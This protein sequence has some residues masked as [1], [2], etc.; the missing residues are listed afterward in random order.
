MPPLHRLPRH[1]LRRSSIL[2]KPFLED[3]GIEYHAPTFMGVRRGGLFHPIAPP[4][5]LHIM[6][7]SGI[8][9]R[10]AQGVSPPPLTRTRT[11]HPI[12]HPTLQ[13]IVETF[14]SLKVV[15][16]EAQRIAPPLVA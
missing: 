13:A 2:L 14:N 16:L 12:P 1:N 11:T 4:P 6:P 5:S 15:A 7:P 8:S 9:A 10:S 3:L